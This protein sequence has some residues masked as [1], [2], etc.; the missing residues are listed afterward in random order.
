MS[1][2]P[3]LLAEQLHRR[4]QALVSC[5]FSFCWDA[6]DTDAVAPSAAT[7]MA[8]ERW[9][10]DTPG[11]R[12]SGPGSPPWIALQRWWTAW[13]KSPPRPPLP[14]PDQLGWRRLRSDLYI[15]N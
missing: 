14:S 9:V 13:S 12:R 1:R 11:P 7:T 6:G 5:A 10:L 3:S 15:P 8:M 4:H 2:G